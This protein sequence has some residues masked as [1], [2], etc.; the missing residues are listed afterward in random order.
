MGQHMEAAQAHVFPVGQ[1]GGSW[2]QLAGS[3]NSII[4]TCSCRAEGLVLGVTFS[5]MVIQ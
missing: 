2:W 1:E 3:V 5:E 4:T